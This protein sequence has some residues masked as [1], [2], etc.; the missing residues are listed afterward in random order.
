MKFKS[1]GTKGLYFFDKQI[2]NMTEA[3]DIDNK[4]L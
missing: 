3:V 4:N 2:V 1:R